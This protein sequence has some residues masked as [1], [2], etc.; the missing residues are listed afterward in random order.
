MSIACT[1]R[2]NS[3]I[4]LSVDRYLWTWMLL[5]LL[6]GLSCFCEITRFYDHAVAH[7][8][9]QKYVIVQVR[10]AP[11]SLSLSLSLCPRHTLAL[12]SASTVLNFKDLTVYVLHFLVF[13]PPF[14]VE[15]CQW[16]SVFIPQVECFGRSVLFDSEFC[17][18][19]GGGGGS[20]VFFFYRFAGFHWDILEESVFVVVAVWRLWA[21]FGLKTVVF[22][23]ELMKRKCRESEKCFSDSLSLWK[24]KWANGSALFHRHSLLKVVVEDVEY[25]TV[26]SQCT[27]SHRQMKCR[28]YLSLLSRADSHGFFDLCNRFSGDV[29]KSVFCSVFSTILLLL[30]ASALSMWLC[31]RNLGWGPAVKS[32]WTHWKTTA[33][34]LKKWTAFR[35]MEEPWNNLKN[36]VKSFRVSDWLDSFDRSKWV[37][38]DALMQRARDLLLLTLFCYVCGDSVWR[39]NGHGLYLFD[40]VKL[41]C[42]SL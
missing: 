23:V 7:V 24:S 41:S 9:P 38:E 12:L 18:A 20:C 29:L 35:A 25:V 4:R 16:F 19:G 17:P 31:T 15:L 22:A 10:L 27:S 32:K 40:Q 21:D 8:A 1:S 36:K 13:F 3:G 11:L 2:A 6:T 14:I 37:A 26:A 39:K 42:L 30:G 5:L 33:V 28:E 34:S